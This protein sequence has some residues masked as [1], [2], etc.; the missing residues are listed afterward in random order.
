MKHVAE[1][2]FADIQSQCISRDL[3]ETIGQIG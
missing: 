2:H 3:E 1:V